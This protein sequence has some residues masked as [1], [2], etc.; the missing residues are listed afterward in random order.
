VLK[1]LLPTV[2]IV[3]D[4]LLLAQD[5]GLASLTLGKLIF[6]A[7]IVVGNIKIKVIQNINV[8]YIFFIVFR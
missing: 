8:L 2:L 3:D 5:I 4:M 1:I 6:P 7:K